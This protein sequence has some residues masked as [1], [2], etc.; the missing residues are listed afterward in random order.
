MQTTLR[1]ATLITTDVVDYSDVLRPAPDND[2]ISQKQLRR[3]QL[4]PWRET[5]QLHV[6]VI[7]DTSMEIWTIVFRQYVQGF[8]ITDWSFEF[9]TWA[10]IN[11][12]N[13]DVKMENIRI[14]TERTILYYRN[15]ICNKYLLFN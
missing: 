7:K 10:A 11:L 15:S 1:N 3:L 4:T 12:L 8:L 5:S 2:V 13:S 14:Y 9:S 6:G